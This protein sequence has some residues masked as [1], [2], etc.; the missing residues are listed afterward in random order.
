MKSGIS[1]TIITIALNKAS[2]DWWTK[3][4][5]D[6]ELHDKIWFNTIRV[7]LSVESR[8]G[9]RIADTPL[10]RLIRLGLID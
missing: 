2:P 5:K 7:L 6:L 4:F 1:G 8:S 9:S 3:V 10:D